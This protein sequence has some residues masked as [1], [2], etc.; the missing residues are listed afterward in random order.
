[1]AVSDALDF[2]PT[3]A[4]LAAVLD[5][6]EDLGA[7]SGGAVDA[8]TRRNALAAYGVAREER[9]VPPTWRH[10]YAKITFEDLVW[11]SGRMRVPTLPQQPLVRAPRE[12]DEQDAPALAVENAGGLVHVGSTYLQAHDVRGDPRVVLLALADAK[13]AH[14]ASIDAV[15][16]K[17]VAPDADRFTALAAAFQNCGAFVGI[18][19]GLV[20]DLP[21][22]IVWASRPGEASAVFPHTVVRVGAGARATIIERFIG[23][24]ESLISAIIWTTSRSSRRMTARA[25]SRTVRRAVPRARRSVG[26][27]PIWAARS[28][29]IRSSH[30]SDRAGRARRSTRFSSRADSVMSI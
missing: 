14:R 29:A 4:M 15:H 12:L 11:S 19:E 30:S 21:L 16:G 25:F 23:E 22:Q 20:L 17:I 8:A 24:T 2:V 7:S 18:P 13:R 6:L 27:S 26:I 3:Q 10:D 9:T 5:E 28:C 1:V